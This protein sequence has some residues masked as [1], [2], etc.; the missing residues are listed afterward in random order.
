MPLLRTV[1][2]HAA[3]PPWWALALPLLPVGAM[4]AWQ[5]W[6][7]KQATRR[8]RRV[9]GQARAFEVH[10][11]QSRVRVL[12]LGDSTGVG[13][14]A[15]SPEASLPGLLAAEFPQVEIVN[16]SCNG[17]RVADVLRQLAPSLDSGER[18]DLALVLAG[19]NDVLRMTP[20][21][22]LQRHARELLQGLVQV[23]ART[24]W[25]GCANIGASP[26]L[27]APLSWWM[28]WQ[29]GR[30]MRLLASQAQTHGAEFIDFFVPRRSDLFSRHAGI[31]FA[32]DGLHPSALSYRHG[33]EVLKRRA[34]LNALL[35]RWPW[36]PRPAPSDPDQET[37]M[38]LVS[39]IMS[40]DVQVI[41]PQESLRRAAQCMQE[42]DVG[43]LPVCED[44]RH[45]L[46]MLTD[47][48]IIVRG[49]AEGLN[50]DSACVSDVMSGDVQFCTPDQ[51]TEEV[52]RLMGDKQVR[53][54]PVVDM[55]K[56]LVGIVA[57]A[58][59]ALRQP[60]RI[61]QAVRE[62]SEPGTSGREAS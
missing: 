55:D 46:G 22:L 49:V 8:S 28:G 56:H 15:G 31:Y 19:G 10:P 40:T 39:E 52:M 21:R 18:Y 34:E 38:P 5:A 43:A 35:T 20:H 53:R 25:M 11:P 57:V 27:M 51:D 59:L 16:R 17:A 1:Y 41:Q 6:Q 7:V 2:R 36:P 33:F 50:P 24:V 14:G 30:T 54:L 9:A 37:A 12:L 45:L 62:I 48:D 44:D 23:A 26:V 29:T 4:A 3:S 42:L 58:D 61:D 13:V 32:D 60:G 47:R